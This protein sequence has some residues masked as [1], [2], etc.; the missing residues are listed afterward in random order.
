MSGFLE[1]I[2]VAIS[3]A[4]D[5]FAVSVAGGALVKKPRLGN[6]LKIGGVFWGFPGFN[7]SYRM[8]HRF[9]F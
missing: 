1:I 9:W 4:M 3:L 6:A 8:G 2:L 7:A 5:C